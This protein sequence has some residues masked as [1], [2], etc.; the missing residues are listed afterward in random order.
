[1]IGEGFLQNGLYNLKEKKFIFNTKK[2]EELGKLWHK[3]IG[4]SSD[5]ILKCL[6]YFQ[7]LDCSSC[8]ICNLGKKY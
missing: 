1:V 6:F 5:K 2:D 3:R 8:E 4:H 7:K